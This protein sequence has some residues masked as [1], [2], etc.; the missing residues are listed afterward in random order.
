M[1]CCGGKRKEFQKNI[2]KLNN[3]APKAKSEPKSG[4]SD[5]TKTDDSK[6]TPRQQR[7]KSRILR[8][9]SRNERLAAR[10]ARI[11]SRNKPKN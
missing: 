6:L 11:E 4:P 5:I 1:A 7:I 9:R 2:A 3:P 8:I 10:K